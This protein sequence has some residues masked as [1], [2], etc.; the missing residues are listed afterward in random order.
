MCA[1]L[2]GTVGSSSF[3]KEAV[4]VRVCS[5]LHSYRMAINESCIV[6]LIQCRDRDMWD[7]FFCREDWAW[8]TTKKCVGAGFAVLR[9]PTQNW[10]DVKSEHT[11]WFEPLWKSQVDKQQVTCTINYIHVLCPMLQ[12]LNAVLQ[13]CG[14]D[15]E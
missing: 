4:L 3:V 14:G 2:P 8:Q 11:E 5:D 12:R 7:D 1:V 6:I 15:V 9:V 13:F 10:A